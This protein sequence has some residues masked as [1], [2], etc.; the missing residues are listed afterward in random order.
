PHIKTNSFIHDNTTDSE[1]VAPGP[2]VQTCHPADIPTPS[3]VP[4]EPE[5]FQPT[6]QE[7]AGSDDDCKRPGPNVQ[8][9]QRAN[10]PTPSRN[11]HLLPGLERYI[12]PT[13]YIG[14]WPPAHSPASSSEQ[15]LEISQS[16]SMSS[17]Q[18]RDRALAPPTE[19]LED[20][21]S[22]SMSSAPRR[23][24]ALAQPTERPGDSP[25]LSMLSP[26]RRGP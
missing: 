6:Q 16:F 22:L 11:S 20:S 21:P 12:L 26:H 19:R 25:S 10:V 2:N 15:D 5:A 4:D 1:V 7:A 9:C 17:S 23:D 3:P 24:R 8:T 18:H 14:P 13:D